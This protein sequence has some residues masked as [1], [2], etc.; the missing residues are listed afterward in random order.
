MPNIGIFFLP[1]TDG[2]TNTPA[3][4]N[5]SIAYLQNLFYVHAIAKEPAEDLLEGTMERKVAHIFME[6][7][8]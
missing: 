5:W 7:V 6:D 4:M 3:G 8:T 1:I 2:K